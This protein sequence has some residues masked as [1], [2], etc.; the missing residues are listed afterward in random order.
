MTLLKEHDLG[1]PARTGAGNDRARRS[2][3]WP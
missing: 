2:T 1:T 3:D